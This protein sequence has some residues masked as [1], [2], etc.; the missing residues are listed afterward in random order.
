MSLIA[1]ENPATGEIL[2][3]IVDFGPTG[4]DEAVAAARLAFDDGRWRNKPISQRVAVLDAVA[5]LIERD[6]EDLTLLETLE[7]GKTLK[8]ACGGD[9]N[10]A[11]EAFRFFAAAMRNIAGRTID[12]DGNFDVH[13]R[14]EPFGVV[15]AI[16][17]WNYPLCLAAWKLA[18]AL[19]CGNSIVL[20]PS[21]LTPYTAMR[22][23]D[24]LE[25]VGL[26]E[27]VV[28]IVNGYG[29]TTGEALARHS[30]VDKLSF[31]GS[32]ATGRK[33][34][35]ASAE[36][37]LK[38]VS[39][40]LGGKSA[41]IVFKDANLKAAVR[42]ALWGMFA[43]QGQVCTAGSRLL[44]EASIHD[45]F[46]ESLLRRVR[47][48]R[49]GDPREESTDLGSLI[50]ERQMRRV[51]DYIASG[52]SEGATLIQGGK[53]IG[54]KGF[55]LE[56][57][58]FT[59]VQPNIRIAQEEIFGPVLSVIPFD[60]E[61]QALEIANGTSY[62]LAAGIWTNDSHRAARMASQLKAG[63]VWINTYNEFDAACPF[64]GVKQSGFGR[65]LG[66]E[67]IDQFTTIKSIWT[68]R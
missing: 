67:A 61:Q 46:L 40:E 14:R 62:G 59:Q 51:L 49:V 68:A 32:T 19:A 64:G 8:D 65:D 50:S 26:P 6:S 28:Q 16:V 18:P 25:E 63:T 5:N 12:V 37:N 15:G 30:D 3:E 58:V 47:A 48:L 60:T 23:A 35:I 45:E 55:F 56:P 10:G 33:L 41:N 7:T 39:L 11:A 21:E 53:R 66:L 20:K 31:T 17:P 38:P 9:V 36:S 27:G 2:G 24:L 57:T 42:G 1:V 29:A 22:L 43:N 34:L 4:V 44:V 52:K 54:D 13:T